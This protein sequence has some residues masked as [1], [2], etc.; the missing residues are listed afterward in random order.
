MGQKCAYYHLNMQNTAESKRKPNTRAKA[1]NKAN[2]LEQ[3]KHMQV[4]KDGGGR[5][6]KLRR[7]TIGECNVRGLN[8]KEQVV[9]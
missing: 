4:N 5:K 6:S 1:M 7:W 8:G 3:T 2:C 9:W